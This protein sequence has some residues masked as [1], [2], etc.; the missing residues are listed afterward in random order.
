MFNVI[1]YMFDARIAW[2]D[3][4]NRSFKSP[5]LHKRNKQNNRGKIKRKL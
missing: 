2:K 1:I 4:A 5:I 3:T